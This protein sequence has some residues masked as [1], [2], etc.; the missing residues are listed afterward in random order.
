MSWDPGGGRGSNEIGMSGRR[1]REH[2]KPG[3]VEHSLERLHI[4]RV[5]AGPCPGDDH[6]QRGWMILRDQRVAEGLVVPED[7]RDFSVVEYREFEILNGNL[8]GEF[9]PQ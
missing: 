9:S 2:V 3:L 5:I 4:A 8:P 7:I 6:N 1:Q